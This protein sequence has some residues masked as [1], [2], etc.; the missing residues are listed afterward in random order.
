MPNITTLSTKIKNRIDTFTNWHEKN[1]VLLK[2]EI[3][4]ATVTTQQTDSTGKVVNVPATLIKVGDGENAFNS[5]PWVSASAADVYSWAKGAT[6]EG[7]SIATKDGT[8]NIKTWIEDLTKTDANLSASLA[9]KAASDHKHKASD[10]TDLTALKNPNALTI[11]LNGTS[12][13]AYDGSQAKEINITPASIGASATGHT[14][15][16]Y[17]AYAAKI[18]ALEQF[19]QGAVNALVFKGTLGTSAN[20]ATIS[21]LPNDHKAGYTYKVVTAGNYAGKTCEV[22]DM[23]ICVTDGTTANNNHWTV[24]QSNIDGAVTGPTSSTEAH[25]AVFNGTTG[26]VIK[27]SGYTIGKSVPSNASFDNQKV[28]GNGQAFN[29]NAVV[30]FI[31]GDNISIIPKDSTTDTPSIQIS[32]SHPAI[33]VVANGAATGTLA[34]GSTFTAITDIQ[35][36]SNGHTTKVTTTTYTLPSDNDTK[37]T[38][39]DTR[40]TGKVYL[41]GT[42]GTTYNGSTQ[43]YVSASGSSAAPG[44]YAEKGELY[45]GGKLVAT[46]EYTNNTYATKAA[47]A[48]VES[49]YVKVNTTNNVSKMFLGTNE[50]IFDCGDA[51]S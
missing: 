41:V 34:H 37:N 9:T 15:E 10:I 50:I 40:A 30:D 12:Q 13:G 8:K 35:K 4:I 49:N 7:V 26:K 32:A 22:G 48:S 19:Q 29:V 1:P 18:A 36:D 28:K 45:S 16:T 23:I 25:V 17:D 43:S 31:P 3:A 27:D 38:V 46:Q 20:G 14:H 6:A 51:N 42:T 33:S 44:A 21:A 5:L 24:V 39:G 2:G 11:K 47:L